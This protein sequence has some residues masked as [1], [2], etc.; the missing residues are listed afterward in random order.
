MKKVTL[1]L[2]T[3][4]FLF[5]GA[6]TNKQL[7]NFTR[8]SDKTYMYNF[9]VSVDEYSQFLRAS[10]YQAQL[11]PDTSVFRDTATIGNQIIPEGF[12]KEYFSERYGSYPIIGITPFQAEQYCRWLLSSGKMQGSIQDVRLPTLN[13]YYSALYRQPMT[14]E[15]RQDDDFKFIRTNN[16]DDNQWTDLCHYDLNNTISDEHFNENT[17]GMQDGYVHLCPVN[18]Y[19]RNTINNLLGNV[20]ELVYLKNKGSMVIPVGNSFA[21]KLTY[22]GKLTN[23]S[24]HTW[25]D[26]LISSKSLWNSPSARI[27]FRY[28]VVL[29]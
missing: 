16:P 14:V 24:Y 18:I 1:T 12:A 26:G 15:F 10:N 7:K 28:V 29:K 2:C 13:E 23:P 11:L 22:T 4:L 9:E 5:I 20:S 3:I 25:D 27:G 8:L 6:N 19:S 17:S 21:G